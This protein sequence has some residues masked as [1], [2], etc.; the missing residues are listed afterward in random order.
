MTTPQFKRGRVTLGM[1]AMTALQLL[2]IIACVAGISLGQV[3]FKLAAMSLSDSDEAVPLLGL[4]T[5]PYL[6][7]GACIYVAATL[8]WIL[9]L[10]N[11]PLHLAYPF[12]ALAFLFVPALGA[13][14]IDEPFSFRT[15]IGAAFIIVGIIISSV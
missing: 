6:I 7:A 10:R 5:S 13:A 8:G 11:V 4:V 15:A 1:G 3:F 14:V 9:V 12:M 2:V